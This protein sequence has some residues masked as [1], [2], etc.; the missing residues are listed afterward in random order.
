M[1]GIFPFESGLMST[2]IFPKKSIPL[3]LSLGITSVLEQGELLDDNVLNG[4]TP[5][6]QKLLVLNDKSLALVCKNNQPK[7]RCLNPALVSLAVR[8]I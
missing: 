3:C 8:R 5:E 7:K 2:E 6:E 4:L 1:E